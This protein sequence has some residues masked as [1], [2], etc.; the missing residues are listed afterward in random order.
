MLIV[1]PE[2]VEFNDRSLRGVVAIIVDFL[3][4]RLIEEWGERG[5]EAGFVD[6]PEFRQRLTLVQ[7]L[8]HTDLEPPVPG[9]RATLRAVVASNSSDRG[10]VGLTAQGAVVEVKHTFAREGGERRIVIALHD[11]SGGTALTLAPATLDQ[12]GM[13]Q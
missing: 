8:T 10:R 9:A 13:D 5:G 4:H 12:V 1:N 6:V 2:R 7:R 3:G 11:P